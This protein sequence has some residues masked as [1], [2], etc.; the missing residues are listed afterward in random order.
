M[1]PFPATHSR[2]AVSEKHPGRDKAVLWVAHA[3]IG[4]TSIPC[5]SA[6]TPRSSISTN[7]LA[8][9]VSHLPTGLRRILTGALI[10]ISA[11]ARSPLVPDAPA[12]Q[13]TTRKMSDTARMGT[14][15][16]HTGHRRLTYKRIA[17]H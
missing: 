8:A 13:Y 9:D 6:R 3:E 11:P 16:G 5:W 10:R 2:Q 17:G 14:L 12:G 4:S 15:M 1:D 7:A